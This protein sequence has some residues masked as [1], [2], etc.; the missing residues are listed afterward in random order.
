MQEGITNT[1]RLMHDTPDPDYARW[2]DTSGSYRRPVEPG[3]AV[4][5]GNE[6][7]YLI[8]GEETYQQM[9]EAIHSTFTASLSDLPFIYLLGW[10]LNQNS[11]KMELIPGNK[12]STLEHLLTLASNLGVQVRVMVWA[13]FLENEQQNIAATKRD[14]QSLKGDVSIILDDRTRLGNFGNLARFAHIGS[15]HQK[16]LI[17]NGEKGLLAFCGGIDIDATR[18]EGDNGRQGWQDVHCRIQGPAAHY[19]LW[20]FRQR[21]HDHPEGKSVKLW[22]DDPSIDAKKNQVVGKCHV[23]VG[24]T[25]PQGQTSVTPI[26]PHFSGYSFAPKG[27]QTVLQMILKGIAEAKTFIYMEDQY[28]LNMKISNALKE[29]IQKESARFLLIVI[30]NDTPG[31]DID[32][33]TWG[34]VRPHRADFINNLKGAKGGEKV[35]VFDGPQ[36]YVHSKIYLFDDKMA[37]IGSANCNRRSMEHDSEVDVAIYD[38]P[39]KEQ[40]AYHFCHR[41]RMRLWANHLNL[42]NRSPYTNRTDNYDEDYAEVADPL[43]AIAHFLKESPGRRVYPYIPDTTVGPGWANLPEN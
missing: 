30:P 42:A 13:R 23:Q 3:P 32:N 35:L 24:R 18:L 1:Y 40:P 25:Y 26:P 34:L 22:G 15:H 31:S 6:A 20:I 8:R 11:F 2:F 27:E 39:G 38:D 37:I 14:I 43:G 33:E 5:E 4:T 7:M 41:L 36:R 19:L 9:V 21:W 28:L 16:V 10:D 12:T 29:F 17:T